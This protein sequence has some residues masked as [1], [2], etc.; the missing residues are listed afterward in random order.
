MEK[1]KEGDKFKCVHSA[2][3]AY[4]EGIIYTLMKDEKTG[5][6]G[7]IGGDGLF[8]PFSVLVSK[9]KPYEEIDKS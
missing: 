3:N 2:S 5:V 4:T 6:L 7:F 8:D 1:K 9:F